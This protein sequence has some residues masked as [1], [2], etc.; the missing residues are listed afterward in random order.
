MLEKSCELKFNIPLN[1]RILLR[2]NLI[3]KITEND[4]IDVEKIFIFC[5]WN[6]NN[7]I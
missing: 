3:I 6:H 4:Y 2:F 7:I 1:S 5:H